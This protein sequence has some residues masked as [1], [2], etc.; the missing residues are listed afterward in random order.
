MPV[1]RVAV[2]GLVVAEVGMLVAAAGV[3]GMVAA[4]EVAAV[5]EDCTQAIRLQRSGNKGCT[6]S[7]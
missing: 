2:V 3:A 7:W 1:I 5:V 4:A 6:H